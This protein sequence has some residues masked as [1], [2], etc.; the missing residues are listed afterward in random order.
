MLRPSDSGA[1]LPNRASLLERRQYGR[2]TRCMTTHD[3]Q[4]PGLF[5]YDGSDH[6]QAAIRAAA[7]QLRP[8]SRALV[9]T[10]WQPTAALPFVSG[11]GLPS[12][13]E[14]GMRQE[15]MKLAAEGAALARSVGFDA[16]GVVDAGVPV[17]NGIVQAA[18]DHDASLI[19][20]GSHGRTGLKRALMGSVATA[21]SSH[22]S[23]P[24]LIVRG[25]PAS[26]AA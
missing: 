12:E 15:A 25:G 22:S 14:D 2:M 24:V 19:V 5:A 21:V 17:W 9:I 3:R 16:T 10:V 26:R 18:D 7:A 23:R 4:G 11:A 13:I 20:M 6:A 1:R 8:S